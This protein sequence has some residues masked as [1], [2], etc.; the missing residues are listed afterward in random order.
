[1]IYG[2]EI[3]AVAAAYAL[4]CISIGYYLTRLR[5]GADIRE[6]GSGSTGARN[7][8]R[9][10]GRRWFVPTLAADFFKGS[11]AAG[12]AILLGVDTWVV[13]AS[14]LGVVAGHIWPI[15]LGFRGGK[16]V[17]TMFGGMAILDIRV[18]LAMVLVFGGAYLVTRRYMVSG[19]IGIAAMP[20][21]ALFWGY[22][23]KEMPALIALT[24]LVILAHRGNIQSA[25]QERRGKAGAVFESGNQG[26]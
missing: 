14:V 11:A 2:R 7:V 9:L 23:A 13:G 20:A 5:T 24:A 19:M 6:T 8:S 12:L 25:M 26:Q 1:M 3:F 18:A 4:G 21:A 10:L 15:Q 17:S 22:G 16:G